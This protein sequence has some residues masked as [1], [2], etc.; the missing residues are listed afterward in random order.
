MAAMLRK[1]HCRSSCKLK[2]R[3]ILFRVAIF[4]HCVATMALSFLLLQ[5]E[6]LCCRTGSSRDQ[7]GTH[8]AAWCTALVLQYLLKQDVYCLQL[9]KGSKTVDKDLH[10]LLVNLDGQP[11]VQLYIAVCLTCLCFVEEGAG[12]CKLAS[13][14]CRQVQQTNAFSLV[15][16]IVLAALEVWSAMAGKQVSPQRITALYLVHIMLCLAC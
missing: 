3:A 6:F 16:K 11:A 1:L 15:F 14:C 13:S 12:Q 4:S 5:S 2:P 8:P 7:H 10:S 9:L